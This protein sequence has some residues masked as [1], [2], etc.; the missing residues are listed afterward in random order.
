MASGLFATMFSWK[1]GIHLD[2][3]KSFVV[4]LLIACGLAHF[5]PNTFEMPHKWHLVPACA[6]GVLLAACMVF[7]Y[8]GDQSPFLY[9]QF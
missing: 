7:I 1:P 2:T 8:G 5:G 3:W 9:F 4:L 6:L